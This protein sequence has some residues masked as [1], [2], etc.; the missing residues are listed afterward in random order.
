MKN[1]FT[2][3]FVFCFLLVSVSSRAQTD[4]AQKQVPG[5]R[6][7]PLQQEKPYVILISADG[8]RHDYA[9]KHGALFLQQIGREYSRAAYLLPS[10]PTLTFPN[11][12]T[13]ATGLYPSHHGL[14][15]N[16]F[17]DRS[18]NKQYSMSNPAAVREPSWYGGT[19]LWVLAEQ[20][21]LLS[22]SF[23]WVGTEAPIA[24]TLPTYYYHYNEKISIQERIQTV[25]NWLEL[26]PE[27]R[28]HFISFYFPEVDHAGHDYGP[29]A[30]QTGA[31]VRFVD[32]ALHQLTAA[33]K[34]TGL[35]VNFVFVADH[36]M[37]KVDTSH[38][39]LEPAIDSSKAVVVS[40]GE[41][42]QIYV[43]NK[44]DIGPMY[45]S[46]RRAAKGYRVMLKKDI[47]R[48]L[49]YGEKDDRW[50][51]IGDIL[52]LSE[53]PYVFGRPGAKIK[54]G[55]HGFDP[56]AVPDM[57]TVFYAWGPDFQKGKLVPAAKNVDVY[58]VVASLLGLRY[59]SIDGSKKLAKKVL[60]KK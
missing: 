47:P 38:P 30:P 54:A 4:T 19:P 6:N 16:R 18:Q 10:F 35:D 39:I 49:H 15:D 29:D 14:V 5:R 32:S 58:P 59:P 43:K 53:A 42:V 57:R 9:E 11:H 37:T 48:R 22:A 36:G 23:Y 31:A 20:Q 56:Y 40:G 8:F 2:F 7:S 55:A 26:P 13:L 41:M 1:L 50:N 52:L 3:C 34:Q 27:I 60:L 24:G 25:I 28:P 33:V 12:Y 46:L 51:R 21:Q 44:A 17:Y 45:D